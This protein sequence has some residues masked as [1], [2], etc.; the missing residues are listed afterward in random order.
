MYS[1]LPNLFLHSDSIW[2]H[3]LSLSPAN[4]FHAALYQNFIFVL[5]LHP[6]IYSGYFSDGKLLIEV[7]LTHKNAKSEIRQKESHGM[8][9]NIK[10]LIYCYIGLNNLFL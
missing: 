10:F 7:F 1:F 5:C 2:R 3:I 9:K 4:Q 6:F 8:F